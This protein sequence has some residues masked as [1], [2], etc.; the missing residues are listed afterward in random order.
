MDD[1]TLKEIKNILDK[2]DEKNIIIPIPDKITNY[3]DILN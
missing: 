1:E 3:I 2:Q